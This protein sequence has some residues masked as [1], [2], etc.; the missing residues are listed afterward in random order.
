MDKASFGVGRPT[1][2]MGLQTMVLAVFHSYAFVNLIFIVTYAAG[3]IVRLLLVF[4]FNRKQDFSC[5]LG[6][7]GNV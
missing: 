4:I 5:Y 2:S 6:F 3:K 7:L 1:I